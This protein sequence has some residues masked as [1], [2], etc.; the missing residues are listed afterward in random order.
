MSWTC[1]NPE[2]M[3][4]LS[5]LTHT[6]DSIVITEIYTI[7]FQNSL[8]KKYLQYSLESSDFFSIADLRNTQGNLS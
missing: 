1:G 7:F 2:S 8:F 5:A 3:T 6:T 4:L